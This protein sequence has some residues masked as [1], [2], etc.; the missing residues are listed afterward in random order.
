M[1]IFTYIH[2]GCL[3]SARHADHDDA[4]IIA[5]GLLLHWWADIYNK[6]NIQTHP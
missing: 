2:K 3:P 5:C 1:C 6:S 4:L